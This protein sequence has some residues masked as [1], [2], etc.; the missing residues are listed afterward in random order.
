MIQDAA[1][2][3][4]FALMRGLACHCRFAQTVKWLARPL[5]LMELMVNTIHL[6]DPIH[7]ASNDTRH[8]TDGLGQANSVFRN[9]G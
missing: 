8:G 4:W 5:S 1:V 2:T 6:A 7:G 3:A 9:D